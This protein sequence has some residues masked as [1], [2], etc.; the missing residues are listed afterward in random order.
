LA[1]FIGGRKQPDAL[2]L[3]HGHVMLRNQLDDGIVDDGVFVRESAAERT[4]LL[5]R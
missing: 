5:A 4:S 3:Q 2:T 1:F